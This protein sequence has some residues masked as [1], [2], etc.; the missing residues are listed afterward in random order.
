MVFLRFSSCGET[1]RS[2]KILEDVWRLFCFANEVL[3]WFANKIQGLDRKWRL[4]FSNLFS[5][6]FWGG[7]RH[8]LE[9]G[10]VPGRHGRE[11][12][13]EGEEQQLE[14]WTEYTRARALVDS[15]IILVSM[16]VDQLKCCWHVQLLGSL[17]NLSKK[18]FTS[19]W[20]VTLSS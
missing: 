8:S 9:N 7:V 14:Y 5:R 6:Y 3:K 12:E 2:Q 18:S 16:G 10:H 15:W 11:D 13:G 19:S 1:W 17:D 20:L 4:A